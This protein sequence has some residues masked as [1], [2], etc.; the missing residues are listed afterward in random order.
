[1]STVAVTTTDT[2]DTTG[3]ADATRTR[4]ATQQW[5][6]HERGSAGYR[7]LLVALVLAGTAIFAQLYAPQAVLPA[8]ARDLRV[9]SSAAALMISAATIGLAIGV[10]PWSIISDRIGRLPAMGIAAGMATVFGVVVPLLPTL[11]LIIADRVLEGFFVGG[12]PAIAMAYLNEEVHRDHAAHAAGTFIGGTSI[13]GLLGRLVASMVADVANWRLA[14]LVVALLCGAVTVVFLRLA[15]RSL[16]FVPTARGEANPDGGVGARLLA[17]LRRPRMYVLWAQGCLLMGGFVAMYNF[18]GFRLEAAPYDLP[19]WLAGLVFLT[20][21]TGTW[22]SSFAGSMAGRFGR[23]P[24]LLV[25]TAA[26]AVGAVLTIASPLAVILVGLVLTTSGFFAAHAIAS[27]WTGAVA[28]VGRAQ[29]TSLYN[30]FYYAG[31]SLFG[32]LGGVFGAGAGWA[33]TAAMIGGLAIVATGLAAAFLPSG[34]D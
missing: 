7:R 12:V 33:G 17:N 34:R 2:T 4:D 31:S 16:L 32:W 29:A 23:K 26:I 18:L 5:Q 11:P 30:L 19:Q 13:G 15:P 6:G 21:L 28:T 8:I 14:L 20:Y 25:A 22:S 10:I 9:G 1:M 24:V 3:A 27:G